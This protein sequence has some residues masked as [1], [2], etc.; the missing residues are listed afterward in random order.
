M[1][2]EARRG[3]G[4]NDDAPVARWLALGG[5]AGG[6]LLRTGA[7]WVWGRGRGPGWWT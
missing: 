7:V 1:P 4:S 2:Q 6:A 3:S 5:T